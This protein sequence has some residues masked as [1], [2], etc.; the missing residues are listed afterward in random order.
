[1]AYCLEHNI[2]LHYFKNS[3]EKLIRGHL[4]YMSVYLFL[5]FCNI[6]HIYYLCEVISTFSDLHFQLLE[7]CKGTCH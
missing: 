3:E 4:I 1:M 2:I 5:L 6:L 7:C